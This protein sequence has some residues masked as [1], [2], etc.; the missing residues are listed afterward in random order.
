MRYLRSVRT[1]GKENDISIG[2]SVILTVNLLGLLYR[3]LSAKRIV[4][5]IERI[6]IRI[7]N[8]IVCCING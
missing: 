1:I 8:G 3:F 7:V 2:I 4:R 5:L 6:V